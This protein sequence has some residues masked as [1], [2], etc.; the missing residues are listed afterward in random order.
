MRNLRGPLALS[1]L[2]DVLRR[3]HASGFIT[4]AQASETRKQQK[5][6]ERHRT[7]IERRFSGLF[8]AYAGGQR[9][10]GNSI[11]EVFSQVRAVD[12]TLL[13]YLEQIP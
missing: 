9:Y 12:A 2:S 13:L 7:M 6:F 3:D 1:K 4:A 11:V 8:V 10:V 5:E